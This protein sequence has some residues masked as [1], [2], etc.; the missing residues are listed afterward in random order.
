VS[1]K[2]VFSLLFVFVAFATAAVAECVHENV[3]YKPLDPFC[4]GDNGHWEY[5]YCTDCKTYFE[6]NQFK[7]EA[8]E[9]EIF[10]SNFKGHYWT[11]WSIEEPTPTKNGYMERR[12]QSG[13]GIEECVTL[14]KLGQSTQIIEESKLS[15]ML[16]ENVL[17]LTGFEGDTS[18]VLMYGTDFSGLAQS[19]Q[20]VIIKF[21]T[22]S[23]TVEKETLEKLDSVMA[24]ECGGMIRLD[25]KVNEPNLLDAKQAKAVE[26]MNVKSVLSAEL[27]MNGKTFEE[28]FGGKMTVEFAYETVNPEQCKL[29]WVKDDGTTEIVAAKF[30]GQTCIAERDHFSVYVVVDGERDVPSMPSTG[31]NSQLFLWVG[32]LVLNLCAFAAGRK[33]C[34]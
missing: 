8:S 13:Y 20:D 25:L 15:D 27:L 33:V 29:Y 6:D 22:G 17:D 34:A 9:D 16:T 3:T 10:F 18:S 19:N 5:W 2:R 28:D 24:A 23:V 7:N 4:N 30:D 31:D 11:E 21:D 12:C 32:L 14:E 1:M 26:N